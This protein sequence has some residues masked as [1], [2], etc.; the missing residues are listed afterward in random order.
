MGK[1]DRKNESNSD[2]GE[3]EEEY[4]VEKIVD[5]RVKNG[6]VRIPLKLTFDWSHNGGCLLFYFFGIGVLVSP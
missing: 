6:K 4:T 1:K 5:R 2:S 3:E